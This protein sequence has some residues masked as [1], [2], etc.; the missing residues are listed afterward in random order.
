[1]RLLV[2]FSDFFFSAPQTAVGFELWS[3]SGDVLF[4]NILVADSEEVAETW[5]AQTFDVKQKQLES[6]AVS[7]DR[8]VIRKI[9]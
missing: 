5:A 7:F 4:D 9:K 2:F 6:E 1:M 8:M 3:I